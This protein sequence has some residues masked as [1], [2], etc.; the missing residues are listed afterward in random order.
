MATKIVYV[1][2]KNGVFLHPYACQ[3]SPLEPGEYIV[4]EQSLAVVPPVTAVN[5]CAVVQAGAWVIKPSAISPATNTPV[6]LTPEQVIANV[7]LDRDA[8]IN[9]VTWKYERHARETRLGLP[10]TD[11]IATLDKYVQDLADV[12]KQIG[13]PDAV[14]W[15]VL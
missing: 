4:P 3:E 1:Y 6:P 13:F 8:L 15:P 5:E 2:D 10:P 12:P 7:K 9:V 14:V 11:V